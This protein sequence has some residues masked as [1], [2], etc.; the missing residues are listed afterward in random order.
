MHGSIAGNGGE[1]EARL[2]AKER[3]KEARR[4][5]SICSYQ[6][7]LNTRP[8]VNAHLVHWRFVNSTFVVVPFMTTEL[9]MK[10]AG[11]KLTFTTRT[12]AEHKYIR[13]NQFQERK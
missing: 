13:Q 5:K 1:T 7:P 8:F 2:S 11:C 6:P 3:K 12:Q 4:R 9:L 10:E